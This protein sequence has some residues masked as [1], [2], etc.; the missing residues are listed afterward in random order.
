M[1]LNTLRKKNVLIVTHTYVKGASQELEDFLVREKIPNLVFIGHP[2]LPSENG[3]SVFKQYSFGELVENR[4][5]RGYNLPEIVRYI[6][7]LLSTI[8]W[9]CRLDLKFDILVGVNNLNA[10][11]C[12][13]LKW[14]G[15]GKNTIFYTIDFVPRRFDNPTLNAIYHSIDNLCIRMSDIVWN[16]SAKMVEGRETKGI[17]KKY[18]AKQITVPI[19]INFNSIKRLSVTDI[20][21]KRVVFLGHLLEK[22][23]AQLLVN[24]A[25]K[26]I[27]SVPDVKF[28]IIGGGDY[29]S[30]LKQ[31]V[32]EL[33]LDSYFEFTGL[34]TDRANLEKELMKGAI[35]I[36]TYAPSP[37]NYTYFADPTKPKD[38]MAFG[39]PVIITD[40]P[41]I[42]KTIEKRKAGFVV[43]YDADDL[44]EKVI[45]LLKDDQLYMEYRDNAVSF[46][47]EYDWN[48][49]F[50]AAFANS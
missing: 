10:L 30:T 41:Q 47:S 29:K 1:Q 7:D 46:A 15:K 22:Q 27:S 32:E 2:L 12:L 38:Y 50:E 6:K 36:A 11:S 40:V 23:G 49:I 5:T 28:Q 42:A 37:N 34:I 8:F 39:L 20:E 43:K 19:G 48:N 18:S 3:I 31:L 9:I 17:P 24:A 35:G 25:P 33:K 13:I 44:A 16:V 4:N 14:L 21:R 45:L 26:I